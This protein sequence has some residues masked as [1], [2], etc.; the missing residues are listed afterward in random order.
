M[1]NRRFEL[2]ILWISFY[3]LHFGNGFYNPF[4]V[5]KSITL[6]WISDAFIFVGL[7]ILIYWWSIKRNLFSPNEVGLCLILLSSQFPGQPQGHLRISGFDNRQPERIFLSIVI[8]PLLT[9]CL[10]FIAVG[11]SKILMRPGNIF[12][13]AP[14]FSY[15][16][17][18][19]TS[20]F[21]KY[22]TTLYL[23][24]SAGIV[25]E[26]FYK[27]ILYKILVKSNKDNNT[28]IIISAVT[29]AL[30]H[31]ESG[32]YNMLVVFIFCL[33]T[34]RLYISIRTIIPLSIGHLLID[35]VIFG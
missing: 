3:S 1:F 31:F 16:S 35:F 23:A 33:L 22:V 28:Y 29:F 13:Y 12:Y 4:L 10:F 7:P 25:E 17:V 15:A 19:P 14:L 8:Y 24:T 34:A 32:S 11:I 20:G 18:I 21:L 2:I 30:A 5:S 6:F 27:G 26:L 9:I